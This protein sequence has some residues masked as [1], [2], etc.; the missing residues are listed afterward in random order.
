M[1]AIQ[2]VQDEETMYVRGKMIQ[3]SF[4]KDSVGLNEGDYEL[5]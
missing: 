1:A 2:C 3:A 4:L 5:L